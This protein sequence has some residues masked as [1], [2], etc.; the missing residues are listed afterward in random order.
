MNFSGGANCRADSDVQLALAIETKIAKR[1]AIR[2]ARNR[3]KFINDFHRAKFRRAGDAAAGETRRKRG[4]MR[5]IISQAAFD[6]G[7]EMLHLRELFQLGEFRH[8]HGTVFANFTQIISQQIGNHYE[9][10][11]LFRARLQFVSKLRI[12]RRVRIARARALDRA[13]DNVRAAH[14]KKLF[15]RR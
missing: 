2:P 6:G 12:A 8:L 13:R 1:A 10:G 11:Q 4:E 9:L 15:R 7:N 14:A 3:F 5:H